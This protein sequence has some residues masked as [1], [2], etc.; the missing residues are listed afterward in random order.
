MANSIK[1]HPES[2]LALAKSAF[3]GS[4]L[5]PDFQRSFVWPKA[6]V[7]ELLVS[8]ISDYFIGNF[9]VLNTSSMRSP[10]PYDLLE[11]VAKINPAAATRYAEMKKADTAIQLTLDG[12][13]RL[14]SILYAL[15]SPQIPLGGAK[16]PCVFS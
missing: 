5:L 14:T 11:G 10:F 4:L 1:V 2:L 15:Y 6:N 16:N 3:N 7:E 8:V 12:Q 9:L 13:Q